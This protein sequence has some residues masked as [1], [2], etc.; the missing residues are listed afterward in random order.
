VDAKIRGMVAKGELVRAHPSAI[1]CVSGI[2]TGNSERR[3]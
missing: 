2:Y 1:H 3:G